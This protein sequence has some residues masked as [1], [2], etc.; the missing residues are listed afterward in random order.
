MRGTSVQARVVLLGVLCVLLLPASIHSQAVQGSIFGN[1]KDPSGAAIPGAQVTVTNLATSEVRTTTSDSAGAYQVPGLTAGNYSITAQ[2]GGFKTF[3]LPQIALA[4][5]ENGR[6]D[7]S[8]QIGTANQT[9]TVT[10]ETALIDT[11]DAAVSQEV[12]NKQVLDLPLN[13]RSF[14]DL[15]Q[16]EPGVVFATS[17]HSATA[18]GVAGG[19]GISLTVNGGNV[20]DNLW[21]LDGTLINDDFNKTPGSVSGVMLGVET[22]QEFKVNTSTYGAE[23]SGMG[24]VVDAVTKS[25][26][27]DFHGDAF[28]FWRDKVLDSRDFFEPASGALP[29]VRRQYGATVGGPIV[30]N[31]TFFFLGYEGFRQNSSSVAQVNVPDNNARLGIING[32]SVISAANGCKITPSTCLATIQ[33]ILNQYPQLQYASSIISDS[34]T[35]GVAVATFPQK[36]FVSEDYLTGRIDEIISNSLTLFSRFTFDQS[37][38]IFFSNGTQMPNWGEADNTHGQYLTIGATKI[39]SSN[40]VNRALYSYTRPTLASIDAP[41]NIFGTAGLPQ[42]SLPTRTGIDEGFSVTGLTAT[43]GNN[44]E[45]LAH[46]QKLHQASDDVTYTKGKNSWKFGVAYRHYSFPS[47]TDF[48][49]DG[50]WSFSSLTSLLNDAATTF[51]YRCITGEN[52]LINIPDG[53]TAQDTYH[54]WNMAFYGSDEW[55]ITPR[56]TATLGLR[57]EYTS[58]PTED[59]SLESWLPTPFL[60]GETGNSV[61][62]GEWWQNPQTYRDFMPRAGIAW[63]VRGNG[64]TAVRAGAGIYDEQTLLDKYDTYRIQGPQYYLAEIGAQYGTASPVFPCP[65]TSSA[66]NPA[67]SHALLQA[68]PWHP[69]SQGKS[70]SLRAKSRAPRCIATVSLLTSKSA[71]AIPFLLAMSVP[72]AATKYL[73]AT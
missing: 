25:G 35:T 17:G 73:R 62:R 12:T 11:T 10:G 48:Y 30:K 23:L 22:L 64:R 14:T 57:Y 39:F 20:W 61:I 70:A 31:K 56:L 55:K 7:V 19:R 65:L 13:G 24:G 42:A 72:S 53:C 52:P 38:G 34:S 26:T 5:G 32:A 47:L 36:G 2:A 63:D 44:V 29:F 51:T 4:V 3:Q 40:L 58:S 43:G 69:T 33:P 49:P 6:Y 59:N 8:M 37:H 68:T 15:A 67:H 71:G 54:Q 50:S 18:E 41:T 66:T 16:L 45:P 46:I 28:G 27:N 9:V 21:L 60:P 1:V